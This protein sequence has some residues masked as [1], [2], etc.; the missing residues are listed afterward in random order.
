MQGRRSWFRGRWEQL[1]WPRAAGLWVTGAA[2][3]RHSVGRWRSGAL[4]RRPAVLASPPSASRPGRCSLCSPHFTVRETEAK[5]SAVDAPEVECVAGKVAQSTL[6]PGGL[7]R[8]QGA[9][10]RRCLWSRLGPSPPDPSLGTP[11]GGSHQQTAARP[12]CVAR[13]VGEHRGQLGAAGTRVAGV[14]GS[15]WV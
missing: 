7:M 10:N 13:A 11:L 8:P 1:S 9:S 12:A 3:T 15:G 2:R 4:W 5:A 14:E 6:G